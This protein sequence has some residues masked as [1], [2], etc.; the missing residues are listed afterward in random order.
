MKID[1]AIET[2]KDFFLDIIGYLIPGL[3]L[4]GSVYLFLKDEYQERLVSL[5]NFPENYRSAFIIIIGYVLGYVIYA[6][7][8]MLDELKKIIRLKSIWK[9]FTKYICKLFNKYKL[10]KNSVNKIPTSI[11][12]KVKGLLKIFVNKIPADIVQE[13]KNSFEFKATL[14]AIKEL[15]KADHLTAD[16]NIENTDVL[17]LRSQAM[18]Y[19]PASDKKIYTFMFRS[20]LCNYISVV[21]K[22]VPLSFLCGY[23]IK[24][25]LN[26]ELLFSYS[27]ANSMIAILL[28]IFSFL[29]QKTRIRFLSIAYKIPFSIFLSERYKM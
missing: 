11:T 14:A 5:F 7:G 16:R 15:Q 19:V 24:Q 13:V 27:C 26:V 29:L 3:I 25:L 4:L 9:L 22:L 18:S 28:F 17:Q 8:M 20:E 21:F 2:L 6:V 10:L 12:Q 23:A 1:D